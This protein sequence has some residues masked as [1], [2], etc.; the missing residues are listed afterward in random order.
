MNVRIPDPFYYILLN[1]THASSTK[2]SFP[3]TSSRRR[4]GDFFLQEISFTTNS[5]PDQRYARGQAA[6]LTLPCVGR[7]PRVLLVAAGKQEIL[8]NNRIFS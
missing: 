4:I 3:L 6:E 8:W 1:R 5:K 2:R 7:A